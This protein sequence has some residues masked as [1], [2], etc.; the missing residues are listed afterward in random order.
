MKHFV[1]R[2]LRK[3]IPIKREQQIRRMLAKCVS[4]R[5]RSCATNIYHC[6]V[7]KTASQW[8]RNIFSA[9]AVYRYSGLLPFHEDSNRADGLDQREIR[10]RD[11]PDGFPEG[12]IVSPLY[13][14]YENFDRIPKP[15]QWRAFFVSRDP[16]DIT[17]SHYFSTRYSHIP[18][19]GVLQMREELEGKTDQEGLVWQ[20][21]YMNSSGIFDALR[22]WATS[23]NEQESI[24][25]VKFEDLVGSEQTDIFMDLL[26]HCDIALPRNDL[27]AILDRL[28]FKK[29]SGGRKQGEVNK[30]HK[31]RS[32]KPGDWASHFDDEIHA[33]FTEKAG[34]LVEAFGYP[35]Q[36][37]GDTI[38]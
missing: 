10:N 34:D 25:L 6:C 21:E 13:C 14:N 2:G 9:T 17:V 11:Y 15:D 24:K 3:L 1:H 32:G 23:V 4:V 26:T 29:L 38:T 22:S 30:M 12:R 31:Y 18:N 33:I 28:S 36:P 27:Q 35:N 8:V 20:I 19:P 5:H 16:R 7:W 37:V